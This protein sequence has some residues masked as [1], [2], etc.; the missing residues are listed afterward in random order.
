MGKNDNKYFLFIDNNIM[1]KVAIIAI[2]IIAIII[3]I[4]VGVGG[5]FAYKNKKGLSSNTEA[6]SNEQ[7]T[8]LNIPPSP[9]GERKVSIV[10]L[11]LIRCKNDASGA[12]V[13]YGFELPDK[14]G[15]FK[16]GRGSRGVVGDADF[17]VFDP[18][19]ARPEGAESLWMTPSL[20]SNPAGPTFSVS[21]SPP[22][23]KSVLLGFVW[24]N[25]TVLSPGE[26]LPLKVNTA[27]IENV[28]V[29]YLTVREDSTAAQYGW[30]NEGQIGL[31]PAR[32][33][34]STYSYLFPA[35]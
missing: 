29:N 10:R 31:V 25:S 8:I 28:L 27:T 3:L 4:G 22:T 16:C 5:Y 15:S 23:D 33:D 18:A 12:E 14:N 7:G 11:K 21:M 26:A 32:G 2:I 1:P 19:G 13:E 35:K 20:L 34:I 24:K 30:R 9:P 17:F 6:P